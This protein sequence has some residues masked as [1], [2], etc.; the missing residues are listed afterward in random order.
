M[1]IQ[2][3]NIYTDLF[4]NK[5]LKVL[6]VLE[7]VEKYEGNKNSQIELYGD[8]TV[9]V[10]YTPLESNR[11]ILSTLFNVDRYLEIAKKEL[12][13]REIID[14]I[15]CIDLGKLIY[16]FTN[17]FGVRVKVDSD[18]GYVAYCDEDDTEVLFN[19]TWETEKVEREQRLA[20]EAEEKA[21]NSGLFTDIMVDIETLDT[22]PTAVILSIAARAFNIKSGKTETIGFNVTIEIQSQIDQGRTTSI[23]TVLWW[24]K[25]SE[26]ASDLAFSEEM[27][28]LTALIQLR[29]YFQSHCTNNTR[30]WSRSPSFDLVVL[31]N[32]LG[33]D[34]PIWEYN[35]E[36]D[37]RTYN[38]AIPIKTKR[39]H[40]VVTH[41]AHEDVKNQ[42]NE[43]CAVYKSI[44]DQESNTRT[45]EVLDTQA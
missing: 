6:D 38:W 5:P 1:N 24:G 31:K 40:Y 33:N 9:L 16:D 22:Q 10:F 13:P 35:Q 26:R 45:A 18:M 29:E 8:E 21:L 14:E 4:F 43:V 23:A 2:E 27:N 36:R 15:Q 34:L 41:I 25:Q 17:T 42:I 12:D 7:Q 19:I 30:V 3:Q 32:A 44:H 28:L 11:E 20:V 37:V 39:K